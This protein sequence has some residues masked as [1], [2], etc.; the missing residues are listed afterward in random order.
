MHVACISNSSQNNASTTVKQ[1]LKVAE[2][3]Y[4]MLRSFCTYIGA[5]FNKMIDCS[6]INIFLESDMCGI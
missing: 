1:I 2:G 4:K 5:I 6:V 3:T